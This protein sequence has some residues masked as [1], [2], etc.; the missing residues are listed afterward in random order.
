MVGIG[1][2]N[3]T[4][5]VATVLANRHQISWNTKTGPQHPNYIG[6]LIR[7][8]TVRLGVDPETGKEVNVPFSDMLPMVHPNDLVLGGWDINSMPLDKA[9]AR[10]QVLDYDLQ[11]QLFPLMKEY[12][13]LPSVYY[14][15]FIA[16]NQED[17]ADNLIAGGDKW[18]HLEQIRKDIRDFKS[19]NELDKVVV[20]WTANTERYSEL[21]D[22]VND[23]ADNLLESIKRSH[24]E[25]SPSTLFAVASILEGCPYINGSP[26]NAFVPGC[27]ELAERHKAFIGGDDF[28]SGQTKFKSVVTEFLV[29]AGIKPLSIAS[30][31]HLGNNDGKNLS[32]QRQFR[33]KEISKSSVVDDMVAANQ[34][35]Y[36]SASELNAE[37]VAAG[38]GGE[39]IKKGEHPD[40]LVVIKYAPAVGDDKR[41]LDEYFS[42]LCMGGRNTLSVFN[43]CE[44]S[45][46][47]TPLILDLTILA[48]LMTRV[49]Y[50]ELENTTANPSDEEVPFQPLYSVLSLLSYM[51][52]APL[53]K[54]GTDVVNSLN[55]QRQALEQF[56]KA[57]IGLD[58]H[59]DLLLDTRIW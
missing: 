12:K 24:E 4:T 58:N 13:P 51:L 41:A 42:E 26:S 39:P 43:I 19:N 49:T 31:N 47:A 17:R 54:P 3:G 48:E 53:V 2:N 38:T 10:G 22:G 16:A 28:K 7:A 46:L 25:V 50:R 23:T 59:G 15:D 52:K 6:S 40:H 21:I 20:L 29:N 55:R 8:S 37:N 14:P 30:Y 32:S 9:M 33:S 35:L 34:L 45:L 36:K 11:R 1:G 18:E 27:I 57:C 44:D 56:M 5:V